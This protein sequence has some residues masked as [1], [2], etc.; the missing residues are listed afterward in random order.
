M[1]IHIFVLFF[2]FLAVGYSQNNFNL[3]FETGILS[4]KKDIGYSFSGGFGY[5]V[6]NKA[7]IYANYL[8]GGMKSKLLDVD[9]EIGKLGVG[10][11]YNLSY[12]SEFGFIPVAGFSYLF[13][14]DSIPLDERNGLGI[15]LG[16]IAAF[17]NNARF[18]YGFKLVNTF[19]AIS[20]GGIMQ[21]SLFFKYNL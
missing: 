4:I 11:Y 2:S 10:V 12:E 5:S 17:N 18:S 9:Y 3:E 13:F 1:K 7:T 8:H 6:G 15:D 19:S 20:F 16:F 14:D 21:G